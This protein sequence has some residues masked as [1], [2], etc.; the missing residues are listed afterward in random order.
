M[1]HRIKKSEIKPDSIET[2]V[3]K[4]MQQLT[5][6][7]MDDDTAEMLMIFMVQPNSDDI[8]KGVLGKVWTA[9]AIIN[10]MSAQFGTE[11]DPK[12]AIIVAGWAGPIGSCVMYSYYM[13]YMAKQRNLMRLKLDDMSWL[14]PVG[15]FDSSDMH[16][17]WDGQKVDT[18]RSGSDNLVDYEI[19]AMSLNHD[20]E[21]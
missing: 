14:F 1:T 7:P 21:K 18:E 17:I 11:I 16:A 15:F 19:A 9:Q 2:M 10:R 12:L 3:W 5:P 20:Q 8:A 4:K 13:Q 6:V